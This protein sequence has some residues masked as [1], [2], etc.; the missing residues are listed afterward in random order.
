MVVENLAV[1]ATSDLGGICRGGPSPPPT[2]P[3]I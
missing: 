2:Y 3:T 1:I